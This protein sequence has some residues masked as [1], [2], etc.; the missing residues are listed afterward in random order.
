MAKQFKQMAFLALTVITSASVFG[1][2]ATGAIAPSLSTNSNSLVSRAPDAMGWSDPALNHN[3]LLQ[4]QSSDGAYKLIGPYKVIGSSFLFGEHHKADMFAV[5]AK[6]YNIFVSYNTYNQEVEFYSTSNPD[7][8]LVKEPGTVDSF[9]IHANVGAG[10]FSELRFYYGS[11]LGVKDKYYFQEI[12]KGTKYSIYK[13]YKSD[14]TYATGN[15][16]TPELRQFDLEVE[17]YYSDGSDKGLKKIK[18][19]ATAVI[20]E[21]KSVKDLSVVTDSNAFTLNP[22]DAFKKVFASLN[23]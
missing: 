16:A 6:A 10:I 15:Y 9:V 14:L 21:F 4:Q 13:R 11:A 12:Y 23:E 8:S 2:G 3:R 22:E 7:K 1:Q 20:K 18:P 17:Y 19:N 5:E